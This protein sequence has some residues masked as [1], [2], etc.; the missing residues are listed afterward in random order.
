MRVA[1]RQGVVGVPGFQRRLVRLNDDCAKKGGYTA[2]AANYYDQYAERQSDKEK[3][4]QLWEAS[5]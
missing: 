4:K 3:A 2:E 1:N 5:R